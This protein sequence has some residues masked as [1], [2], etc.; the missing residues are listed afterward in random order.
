MTL[1]TR[2]KIEI[3]FLLLDVSER[4]FRMLIRPLSWVVLSKELTILT[5]DENSCSSKATGEL[6][7]RFVFSGLAL[8]MNKILLFP[9]V[10]K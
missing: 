8:N 2:K 4:S 5:N 3:E 7:L 9:F 10:W 1:E 6:S